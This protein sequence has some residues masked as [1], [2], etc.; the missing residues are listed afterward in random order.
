[1]MR[2]L[3]VASF[4][5]TGLLCASMLSSAT[6]AEK[7]DKP[8]PDRDKVDWQWG[9]K[10]PLAD[11]VHLNATLYRPHETREPV[12]CVFT[13]TPYVSDNYHDRGMYFAQHGYVFAIVDV[14]GRGNS[15]GQFHPMRE[16]ADGRDIVEWLARQPYCNGKIAMWGG[17]YAGMDQ[18]QAAS[19]HPPHLATIVPAAAA[20]PSIDAP[21]ADNIWTLDEMQWITL[22]TGRAFNGKV[23]EDSEFWNE[24][25]RRNA[26]AHL[27][28]AEFDTFIG[29]PSPIF[30][31]WVSHPEQGPYWDA[32]NPTQPEY[33][34][35]E[36]PVLTI[37]G[38]YDG[39]QGGALEY[40]RRHIAAAGQ[41]AHHFLIIGPWDHAQTRTP[42]SEVSG[43]K[44]GEASVLDLN[45][46]HRQWY[47]W[48]MKS[49]S[50]PEFLKKPVAWYVTGSER[51][52]YTD[53]LAAVT[54]G[55]MPLY[56]ASQDGFANDPVRS[57]TL[58]KG[59]PSNSPPDHYVYDPLDNTAAEL[60]AGLGETNLREQRDVLQSNGRELIYHT[61]PFE[62][63][64]ELSG[65][66]GLRAW[67][68]VDQPDTDV[69]VSVYEVAPDGSSLLLAAAQMRARY[70]ESLRTAKL[71]PNAE[72]LEYRF[73]H[74]NFVARRIARGS[75]LRL[76]VGP[77][78]PIHMEKNYN[79]GGVV[80]HES[81]KDARTV[82]V[83][84][85]HDAQHP[86]ALLLP[87]GATPE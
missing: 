14:R 64:T 87:L 69:A 25:Y 85:L 13:L 17:S 35:I 71:V 58:E 8:A 29:N 18:W 83:K 32:Y 76:V 1:M 82:T 72:P 23:Y 9:I 45:D 47:D 39:D 67:L 46:L 66:F 30:R 24:R 63:D 51:W 21:L 33:A 2:T 54:S 37:T 73:E 48:T 49:G 28:Y 81:G 60:Q 75:R 70:R 77:T 41:R 4:V 3:A 79:S 42:Q 12:P 84:L 27:P 65:F 57:G 34:A 78:D 68:S 5:I 20:M 38:Q 86:S 19:K 44:V 40:Y 31:E 80:A 53:S 59:V 22:V 50:R 61:A 10:I 16:A 43:L 7:A 36:I 52:R 15:E 11:G 26:E 62:K 74:F 55:I 6:A 56:L